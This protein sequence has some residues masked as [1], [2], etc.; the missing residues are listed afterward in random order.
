MQ[1]ETQKI[2]IATCPKCGFKFKI[3]RPDKGGRYRL[4]CKSCD[5]PFLVQIPDPEGMPAA[6]KKSEEP[7]ADL[8][9][10]DRTN[11]AVVNQTQEDKDSQ[12][13]Q[14]VNP[15]P[16][17]RLST[18]GGGFAVLI[19]KRFLLPDVVYKLRT[20]ANTIGGKDNRLA[21][22][23]MIDDQ[24]VSR[25]SVTLTVEQ[26]NT[27]QYRYLFSVNR[28]TNP[29]YLNG[30][31]VGVSTSIYIEPGTDFQLGKTKFQLKLSEV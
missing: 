20:G 16:T 17:K 6:E 5:T 30:R 9:N 21:S 12:Y 31:Q 19:R 10:S 22:D 18:N 3:L 26:V 27:G 14:E 29:V 25:R 11:P 1:I 8:Q 13:G 28:S 15:D 4:L 24:T 7:K 2:L 23:I